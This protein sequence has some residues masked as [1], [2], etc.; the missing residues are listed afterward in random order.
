MGD[1]A[2]SLGWRGF[3]SSRSFPGDLY[4]KRVLIAVPAP[5]TPRQEPFRINHFEAEREKSGSSDPKGADTSLLLLLPLSPHV[6]ELLE[7]RGERTGVIF[8]G[9]REQSSPAWFS[10]LKRFPAAVRAHPRHTK[11]M[12]KQGPVVSCSS[13]RCRGA[14]DGR[15]GGDAPAP[16]PGQGM[17]EPGSESASP[18]PG[19]AS[20]CPGTGLGEG[21]GAGAALAQR[22]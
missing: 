5:V 6:L 3:I 18:S 8:H 16:L 22:V 14:G 2:A 19:T 13:R 7:R 21:R 11:A 9:C 10:W 1:G 15:S 17:A 4:P 12:H 20:P